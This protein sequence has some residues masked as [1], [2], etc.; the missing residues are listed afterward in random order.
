MVPEL[1]QQGS[2]PWVVAAR[3]RFA[4]TIRLAEVAVLLPF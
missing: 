2:V 4:V 1:K 3:A